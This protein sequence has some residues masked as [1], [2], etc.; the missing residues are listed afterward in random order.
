METGDA[1]KPSAW[2]QGEESTPC[3][4]CWVCK[5]NQEVVGASSPGELLEVMRKLTLMALLI[6]VRLGA[7]KGGNGDREMG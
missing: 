3:G 1:H 4:D 7:P 2:E 6:K 5:L